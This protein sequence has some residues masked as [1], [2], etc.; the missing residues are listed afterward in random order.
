MCLD[1][2]V[3]SGRYT[4]IDGDHRRIPFRCYKIGYI[5]AEKDNKFITND[6]TNDPCLYYREQAKK[7]ELVSF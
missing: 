4:H 5:A 2:V 7:L 1:F 6:V 3:N